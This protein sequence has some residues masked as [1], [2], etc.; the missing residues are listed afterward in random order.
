[1]VTP[2]HPIQFVKGVGP[3]LAEILAARGIR[4]PQ[5]ALYLFPKGYQDRRRTVPIREASPGMTV[6]VRGKVLSVQESGRGY[7][8][9][10]PRLLEVVLFDGTGRIVAKWFR[11][12]PS[13]V[14][15]FRVGEPAV[16]CGTV[17]YFRFMPEMH[18]PEILSGEGA[19]DP[20]HSGR[21]VPIYPDIEGI[22]PRVLRKIQWEVV[23][24]HAGREKECFPPW[25]LEK[26]GVPPLG[27]SLAAIHFPRD[28]ADAAGFLDHTS[29]QRK[30]LVFGEL[31]SI[32]WALALR[33]A[34]I[35]REAAVPLPWDREIV[36]EI[37]RRLPFELTG[38]QRRTIN[39]ILKDM[40][41]PHPMHR[42]LQG[43]VGSGKTIVSWIAAMVAWKHGVQAAVMAPTEILAE[44]HYRRF[45]SLSEGLSARVGLLSAALPPKE[46]EAARRRIRIGETDI[47][48]GTHALI[49]ESVEFHNL[50]FAVIDEQ[51]R[52]GVLQRAALREKAA[53]S[54]HLLVMT[55]TPIPRTLAIA[56]Y[57]DLDIS[58]IDEMPKGRIP[59]KTRVVPPEGRG[60]VLEEIRRELERGGRAYV[61]L[62]LVEESEKLALRDAVRT[63]E[64]FRETFPDAGVGLLH[65]RMKADEKEGA[66]RAFKAGELRLLVSTTVVEVGVD[67]PEATVIVIE[68]AERFGLS[69]L[70]QLR[71][72]VG[73]GARP[74][75]CF[76][77]VENGQGEEAAARLA[78][79]ERTTD[80]FRIAEEDLKIRGPGDFAGVRQSGI[81]D[82]VFADLV[83]DAGMLQVAKEIVEELQRRDPNLKDPAHEEIRRFLER[84]AT[85]GGVKD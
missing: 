74:S 63:A 23:H 8:R 12:H 57:G 48:V 11:Y 64:R 80:G 31:F 16:V 78:V 7:R 45:L 6:P 40:G 61:V 20:I 56:L 14:K 77:M 79:M 15:R 42:L 53:V 49:Q 72:R 2:G 69:Q 4:T 19:D 58:V 26:A 84:R 83:R 60:K 50:A 21:I 70:H 66:M 75:S 71:G 30:R 62:P 25:I 55:A 44:Q 41:R 13:L 32:Q 34:G 1:M 85:A 27:E 59:V 68:H 37:K 17:R 67:V 29:P 38:A 33:R 82:L 65:G 5:D 22:P 47:V 28:D 76:L 18:H 46:R 35:E 51:H 10:S 81:P 52:F 3:R 9:G 43:D 24:G 39:E 36:D 73:R 54:P